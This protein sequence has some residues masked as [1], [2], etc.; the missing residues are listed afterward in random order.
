MYL[1]HL[2][3]CCVSQ[4]HCF[5]GSM[6]KLTIFAAYWK[7]IGAK[8][9]QV[10]AMLNTDQVFAWHLPSPIVRG[11]AAKWGCEWGI[12][13]NPIVT[14]SGPLWVSHLHSILVYSKN[15]SRKCPCLRTHIYKWSLMDIDITLKS[16]MVF[17]SLCLI[18]W[19]CTSSL[20]RNSCGIPCSSRTKTRRLS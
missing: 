4:V 2:S 18:V 10:L 16:M 14:G 17:P 1:V 5:S 7:W 13:Y 8:S 12:I 9:I 15:E 20:W 11:L 19:G 3:T 6:G